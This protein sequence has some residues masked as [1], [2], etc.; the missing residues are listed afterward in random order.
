LFFWSSSYVAIRVGLQSFEPGALGLARYTIAGLVML[1]FYFFLRNKTK[2]NSKDLL[3]LFITGSVGIGLY[4]ISL[5]AGEEQVTAALASFIISMN[6][7]VI[8]LF[9][10][11]FLKERMCWFG[12]IGILISVIGM[13]TIF[14][15]KSTGHAEINTG[16][17]HILLSVF[18]GS[19]YTLMQKQLVQKF[20][21]IEI[22]F[23]AIWFAVLVSLVYLPE[24][25]HEYADVGTKEI[26]AT[27]YLGVCPAAF[28]YLCWSYALK[29][30]PV[31]K[32][33]AGLFLLPL[34]TIILGWLI[35]RELPPSLAIVGGLI[36]L[37]GAVLVFRQKVRQNPNP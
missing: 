36:S 15:A 8:S 35:L 27:I 5:N 29:V 28:G 34:V 31:T 21:P 22:V 3:L 12:W 37:C 33:S 32:V 23:W 10:L 16:V 2:P 30:L 4:N 7:V 14:I 20:H 24:F 9:A 11:L 19:F 26:I 13:L 6:P 17:L 18:C 1:I 25:I